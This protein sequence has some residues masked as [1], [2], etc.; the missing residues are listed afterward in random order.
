MLCWVQEEEFMVQ[1]LAHPIVLFLALAILASMPQFTRTSIAQQRVS[2]EL[3]LATDI[4]VSVDAQEYRLQMAGIANAL[5]EPEIIETIAALPHGVAISLVHWSTAHLNSVAVDWHYLS[6]AASIRDF[7]SRIANTP[8]TKTGRSTAIGDAI[9]FS[10][11]KIEENAFVGDHM[12]IDI[13]G[14]ER[15]NSGPRP[16]QARDRAIAKGMTVNGLAIMGADDGLYGYFLNFVIGGP[17]AFVISV[18]GYEDFQ[19]AMK[20]KLLLELIHSASLE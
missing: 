8:R 18:D 16:S 14:D 2:I 3:V 15:S 11:R 20:Q 12:R 19:A 17:S 13:S 6:D 4:S 7:A 9:D 1:V 5:R 10:R